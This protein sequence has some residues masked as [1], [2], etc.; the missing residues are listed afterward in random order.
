MKNFP[1]AHKIKHHIKARAAKKTTKKSLHQVHADNL[2]KLAHPTSQKRQKAFRRTLTHVVLPIAL[3]VSTA[4]FA[5]GAE[6][7]R[8]NAP[9]AAGDAPAVPANSVCR[10]YSRSGGGLSSQDSRI[11]VSMDDAEY[12]SQFTIS[13]PSSLNYLYA[14]D[15]DFHE[16]GMSSFK[17]G[18]LTTIGPSFIQMKV[19]IVNPGAAMPPF[20]SRAKLVDQ[21]YRDFFGRNATA[22]EQ[23]KWAGKN[24]ATGQ[25]YTAEQIVNWFVDQD[26]VNDY[27]GKLV[28]LYKAYYKRWPDQSGYAYW[29]NKQK[30]GTS[31][32]KISDSFASANEFKTKYG[33]VSNEQFVLLVYNN[34]LNRT[35]DQGGY[36]YWVN[37]LNKKTIT[38]GGVMLAFSESSEY[39]RKYDLDC[40]LVGVTL[41]MLRRP[42]TDAELQQ[43]NPDL[44]PHALAYPIL[45]ETTEYSNRVVK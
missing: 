41:R 22:A 24:P 28:R 23:T 7:V 16:Y 29:M 13:A 30:S 37:K 21:Q 35:P 1:T 12:P 27:R 19:C 17:N 9:K 4:T 45:F 38:R 34:V 3:V 40:Q 10:T 14:K 18:K 11:V 44:D 8:N 39:K 5:I 36:N 32:T 26:G 43:W 31:L 15:G 33:T 2:Y 25:A 42:A 6:V 20:T